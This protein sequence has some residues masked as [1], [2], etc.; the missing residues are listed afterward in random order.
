MK[1]NY[2]QDYNLSKTKLIKKIINFNK[3]NK[4]N[5]YEDNHYNHTRDILALGISLISQNKKK[6]Q[7]LDYGSNPLSLANLT[8]KIKLN[9]IQFTIYDPFLKPNFKKTIIKNINY[10]ILNNDKKVFK[11]KYNLIHFGSSIQYQDNFLDKIKSLNLSGTEYLVITHTPFSMKGFYKTQ[12]TNHPN[13]FQNIYS[14]SK[15][16]NLFKSKNFKLVFKSVNNDKYKACKRE[17]FKTYSFNLY[18]KKVDTNLK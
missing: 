14:F 8:N 17:V 11:K 4:V 7:V 5:Y 2:W 10:R 18:F 1:P 6:I 3:K 13:L 16:V 9:N 15:L 12:Q